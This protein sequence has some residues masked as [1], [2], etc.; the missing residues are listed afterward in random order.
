MRGVR[1]RRR[2]AS[3][4]RRQRRVESVQAATRGGRQV[5][6]RRLQRHNVDADDQGRAQ[7]RVPRRRRAAWRFRK[8]RPERGRR[9]RDARRM[10]PH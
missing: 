2:C 8:A 3:V 5:A 1:R 4:L 10:R 6:R 9:G 7:D